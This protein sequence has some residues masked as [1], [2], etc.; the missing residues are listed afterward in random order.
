[1]ERDELIQKIT[2]ELQSMDS[3]NLAFVATQYL[4]EIV[5]YDVNTDTF[6]FEED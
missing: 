6:Q 1:M 3:K 2:D 4:N 5:N